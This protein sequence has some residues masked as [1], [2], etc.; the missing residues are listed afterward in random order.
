[1]KL[2]CAFYD[3]CLRMLQLA[4]TICREVDSSWSAYEYTSIPYKILKE[5]T[6]IIEGGR[7]V[8]K[9]ESNKRL[10]LGLGPIGN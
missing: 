7:K 5:P 9:R 4:A 10:Q 3:V 6:N 1:M 8:Q 2:L